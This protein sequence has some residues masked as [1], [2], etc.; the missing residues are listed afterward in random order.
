MMDRGTAILGII[1]AQ[2]LRKNRNITITTSATVKSRVNSMSLT[3]ARMVVV[4]LKL[5]L[6]V[7]VGGMDALNSGIN[8]LILSTVSMMLASGCR[9]MPISTAVLPFEYPEFRKS[10]IPSATFAISL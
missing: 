7:T 1:V 8:A 2:A 10:S 9:P 4:R 5:V 6:K 3:D